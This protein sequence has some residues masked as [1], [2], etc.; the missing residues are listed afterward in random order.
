MES[1]EL[2]IVEFRAKLQ[3]ITTE[4]IEKD[5]KIKSKF[6]FCRN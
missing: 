2:E 1:K 3:I 6:E 5:V 4:S